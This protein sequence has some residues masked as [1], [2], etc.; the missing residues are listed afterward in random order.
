MAT[1]TT[2]V[3]AEKSN[4]SPEEIKKGIE[5][6]KKAA[7]HHEEA[8]RHHHDAA[9]HQEEGDHGKA[10]QSTLKAQGHLHHAT[11]TLREAAKHHASVK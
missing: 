6:H 2:P 7:K 1:S 4:Q 3:K 10:A 5:N 8:A 11:E 9:K